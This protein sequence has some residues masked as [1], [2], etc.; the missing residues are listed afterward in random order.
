MVLVNRG[1]CP[2]PEADIMLS[3]KQH[4]VLSYI[5]QQM[6]TEDILQKMQISLKTFYCHKHSVMM[7]LNLRRITELIKYPHVSY[8]I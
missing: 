7:I 5:A 2:A 8:L 3:R 1:L 6:Q 4:Q